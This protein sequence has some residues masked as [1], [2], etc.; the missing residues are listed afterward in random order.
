M[1]EII[2]RADLPTNV[3]FIVGAQIE[4][5]NDDGSLYYVMVIDQNE[6]EVTLD[7]NHPLAGKDLI[8][9]IHVEEVVP[10][11]K[12]DNNPL[13]EIMGKLN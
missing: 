6:T 13:E 12:C 11:K 1:I 8:F 2:K 3:E 7:G 4:I 10:E 9:D 5:S